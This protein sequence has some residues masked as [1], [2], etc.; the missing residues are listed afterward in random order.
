MKVSK[1]TKQT[2]ILSIIALITA[3][4]CM[5]LG[6]AT[7]ST[8]LT[9]SSN[10]NVTPDSSAFAVKFSTEKDSL[11]VDDVIPSRK[12]EATTATNGIISNSTFPTIKNLK[13]NFTKPGEYVEYIFYIRNEGEYKAYLNNINFIGNKVCTGEKETTESLVEKAC[14]SISITATIG[15]NTYSTTNPITNQ[16]LESRQG[17]EVIVRLS[18]AANSP[19][20]DGDFSISFPNI[21]VVYSSIDNPYVEPTLPFKEI[22]L[23]SGSLD[24]PGSIVSIGDEQFYVIDQ[25]NEIVKLLSMFNLHVGNRV[26]DGIVTTIS[27]PTGI[28]DEDAKGYSTK[29]Y[30]YI[31]TVAYSSTSSQYTGS[32]IASHIN[33]YKEYLVSLGANVLSARLI[34]LAELTKL[35]CNSD[36]KTCSDAPNWVTETSY[37]TGETRGNAIW[38]VYND[39][40][41]NRSIYNSNNN[42]GVRPVIEIPLSEF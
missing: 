14:D 29:G 28:Q 23:K 19:S 2:K 12:T 32:I 33:N 18:Y 24:I 37:W 17:K 5:S 6:F 31:G 41:L 39:A 35:E 27:S 13:A 38:Y 22:T 9:I 1:K 4:L 36:N 26:D 40:T 7:F 10:A 25:E 15:K 34:T 30:P 42:L 20:V 21:A 11:V 3:V 8:T 16:P